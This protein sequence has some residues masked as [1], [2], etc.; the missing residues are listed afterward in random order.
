MP[1]ENY[2]IFPLR[3][4]PG[5]KRDSTDSEGNYWSQ[6][7]WVRFYR[8]LPQSIGGYR[9]MSEGY[10]G[11]SRGLLVNPNG[12]GYLNI[13]SGSS[14]NLVVGQ[15]T[16]DGFGSTPADITPSGFTASSD[17]VWQMD[18]IYD[19]S[20]SPASMIFA[21]AAP[22]LS[23]I[24]SN[25]VMPVYYGNV[26]STSA[27]IAAQNDSS[28]TFSIDGGIVSLPPLMIAYGSNG[29]FCWSKITSGY[30]PAIFPVA[31]AA[32]ICAT[33]IVK[34]LAIRGGSYN[35]SCLLWSLDSVIQASY[36]G[37]TAVWNFNTISDQSSILSS[38][39]VV[40]MD[41]IYYWIGIDRFLQFTGVLKEL[42]NEINLQFFFNN[43][44]YKYRQKAFA[45]KTPQY[46]E[47]WF[48]APLFGATECNWAVIYNVR[49]NTWYDTPL[50]SDGRSAAYFA[51][52]W[53][54]PVLSSAM[55]M[56]AIGATGTTYPIWQHNL[57][58]DQV[59]GTQVNAIDSW[60]LSPSA[61]MVG[62]NLS[63]WSN[64]GAQPQSVMTEMAF[65]EPDFVMGPSLQFTTY[66][67]NYAMDTDAVLDT[68]TI[69]KQTTG[70]VYDLQIQSRY[71]RWKI[72]SNTQGGFFKMGCPMLFYRSGD[73]FP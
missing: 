13:F 53:N 72:E 11:P 37:G 7:Q 55:G 6:G 63:L 30:N 73:S 43:L 14:N 46:G 57:G 56:P 20:G 38:S 1:G 27:L 34:G 17:N 61:S 66:G 58:Y 22:N 70:N 42:P 64:P 4:S 15:F 32:N 51:Q 23:A 60:I 9:S 49:E 19:P 16:T 21:H 59:R 12:S 68:R 67:R 45:F 40:E 35:P 25:V 52:T 54:Y 10:Y 50:P 36:V 28:S 69:T 62:G 47:I 33:K 31:N 71:L 8:G 48:C 41:G 26:N 18:L 2:K 3:A 24:D 39:G 65:M 44:N 5:I 29:L